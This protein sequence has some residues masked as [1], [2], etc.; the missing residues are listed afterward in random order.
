MQNYYIHYSILFIKKHNIGDD[1]FLS[2]PAQSTLRTSNS[3]ILPWIF[4]IFPSHT[5]ATFI[6]LSLLFFTLPRDRSS[7]RYLL[8]SGLPHLPTVTYGFASP[9]R[10]D[11]KLLL[12]FDVLPSSLLSVPKTFFT[13]APDASPTLVTRPSSPDL[14]SLAFPFLSFSFPFLSFSFPFISFAFPFILPE[15]DSFTGGVALQSISRESRLLDSSPLIDFGYS[16]S[17]RRI[18]PP[19]QKRHV[20]A[21]LA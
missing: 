13:A 20:A 1:L 5:F 12:S 4:F 7:L 18:K 2:L 3:P 15:D 9:P 17:I 8:L 21:L 6:R 14:S 16:N 11:R 19:L 10:T